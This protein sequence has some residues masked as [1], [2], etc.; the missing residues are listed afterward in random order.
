MEYRRISEEEITALEKQNCRAENWSKIEVSM[1]FET[2]NIHQVIF[3]G[4]CRLGNFGGKINKDFGQEVQC[5]LYNAIISNTVLEDH[6]LIHNV[7]NLANYHVESE[8]VIENVDELSV[9]GETA[10]GNGQEIDV[11]N[12]G[13]GRELPIFDRLSSQLAYL[14]VTHRHD[15]QLIQ[16]LKDSISKYTLTWK[17]STGTICKGSRIFN[18]GRLH[19]VWIGP[20]VTVNGAQSL[21]E[22]TISGEENIRT[23][24]GSGVIAKKFI[25][26]SGSS[27][28]S[29]SLI[30]KTFIGQGVKIG[31]QFSAENSV[32][33]ANSEGFHSEAVSVFAGP[34]TVT[35]HKSTLLIAG[36]FS[37][38][39]A[40]SGT[41]Q[42]NHM[43]KLGPLHQGIV[44]RGSK[45][46]SFS[47]L[48]WP[49]KVGPFS[50]VMGKHG[51]N[52]DTSDL[53]FSYLTVEGEKS[54]LTPAMNLITVGTR[55]DSVKWPKRDGRKGDRKLDLIH[56]DLFNPFII[57]KVLKGIDILSQLYENTPKEQESVNYNGVR[58]KRLMLKSCRKY[59][60]MALHIFIGDQVIRMLDTI[61]GPFSLD[62]I[63][64]L[65]ENNKEETASEWIDMAGMVVPVSAL[66]RFLSGIKKEE[67]PQL[68]QVEA[69]LKTLYDDYS[70]DT[71]R[72]TLKILSDRFDIS[73]ENISVE[74]IAD[75]ITRWKENSI[76]LNNMIMSDTKKEFDVNSRIGFGLG[77]DEL[78]RNADFKQVR[79]NF[80]ENSFV[81]GLQDDNRHI[82]KTAREII[83]KFENLK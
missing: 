1:K 9:Y 61:D 57:G 6:I 22:G 32:F 19:N 62:S 50:V 56:F 18:S 41:N 17:S 42:S 30:E 63:T 39:N 67:I 58:I 53:P 25:I 23:F 4:S 54:I 3:R 48:L 44:E 55:R 24:V 68:A 15:P 26:Q 78:V 77:G 29:G 82:E 76:R 80:E 51:G 52:F 45:T 33:F 74:N 20:D 31:R 7:H 12:E 21:E 81:T 70:A 13:G 16:I 79:G 49:T 47:Y 35:H 64:E 27:V 37:F 46:G 60:E 69:G 36:M 5:G 59:Y 28:D 66:E 11:L 2:G 71:W 8:V 38:F 10:F 65:F 34:Y 14:I 72:F 83:Q 75:L 73:Q 40:G 43:Y